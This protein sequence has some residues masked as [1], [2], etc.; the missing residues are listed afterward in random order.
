ML[1]AS[2]IEVQCAKMDARLTEW[3]SSPL[4]KPGLV[5]GPKDLT[6]AWRRLNAQLKGMAAYDAQGDLIDVEVTAVNAGPRY[7]VGPDTDKWAIELG[8]EAVKR[9]SGDILTDAEI[10]GLR[11]GLE[12]PFANDQLVQL[13]Y[14]RIKRNIVHRDSDARPTSSA[15]GA[16]AVLRALVSAATTVDLVGA[17]SAEPATPQR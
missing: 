1:S 17:S 14:A 7:G 12:P 15:A 9:Q 5:F 8:S 6:G 10:L 11:E 3:S 2:Q 13:T 4:A 16:A